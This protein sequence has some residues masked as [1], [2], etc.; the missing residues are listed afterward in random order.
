M[1]CKYCS[2]EISNNVHY[3]WCT[4]N[5]KLLE[6]KKNLSD[7]IKIGASERVKKAHAEGKYKNAKYCRIGRKHTHEAK[8]KI[9]ESALKSKHR[10]LLKSTRP[11]KTIDGTIVLLDS[12]WEEA[13]AKRLD[14]IKVKWI[15]PKVPI[16]WK[17]THKNVRNYFPDFYLPDYN[18]YLDPK[19]PAAYNNQIEKINALQNCMSNL[20]ILRTLQECIAFTPLIE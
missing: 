2:N 7:K 1:V 13:L 11:Y 18:L 5:P 8:K 19:N 3:R 20:I 17:D 16:K 14:K 9:S 12:S 4:K 10:R 6:N 15:R